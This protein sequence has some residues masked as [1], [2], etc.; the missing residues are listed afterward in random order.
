[1]G[2]G[3][4]GRRMIVCLDHADRRAG[5]AGSCDGCTRRIVP[6]WTG[7]TKACFCRCGRMAKAPRSSRSS[8]RRMAATR[9]WCA[10]AARAGWRRCCSPARSLTLTWRA[11][12][13]DH[14]GT[15]TVEP[16][17]SRAGLMARPAGAGRA[18]R[19]LRAAAPR[20]ARARA[21]SGALA[22]HAG[23]AGCAGRRAAGRS[24]YLRWELLLL[25]ELGFGLDLTR[26]AVTG[27]TEG[28]AYVS[29][30]PAGR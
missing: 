1:M 21:A 11:R 6:A 18:E 20:P 8:R 24:A 3:A 5:R 25:E 27:A 4:V 7:A 30:R 23:A 22:R 26:C 2:Y 16:L 9:A 13:D 10:A 14:L 15:F 12:L 19:G 29:P 28:L 17:R